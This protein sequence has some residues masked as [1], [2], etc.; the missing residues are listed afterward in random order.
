MGQ[1]SQISAHVSRDT[2]SLLERYV[3]ATGIKKG[4]VIEQALRSY[5]AGRE[6][7]PEDVTIPP[8]V[9]V[10]RA[11]GERVF[12]RMTNPRPTE[13]LRRLLRPLAR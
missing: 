9:V 7:I 4:H 2:R 13:T 8:R 5:L 11:S 6:A 10:T 1:A 3:A 12:R